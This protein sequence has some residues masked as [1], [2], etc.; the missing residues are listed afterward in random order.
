MLFRSRIERRDDGPWRLLTSTAIFEQDTMAPSIPGTPLHLDAAL[1]TGLRPSYRLL[2][3]WLTQRGHHIGN[4]RYGVDQP[5][6]IE[7][8][9]QQTLAWAELE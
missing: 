2:A 3:L 6:E 8:L 1:L 7:S 5:D 4:D 9:Y